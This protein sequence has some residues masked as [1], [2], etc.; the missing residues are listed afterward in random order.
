[1]NEQAMYDLY[2]QGEQFDAE[3]RRRMVELWDNRAVQVNFN[4]GERADGK[5]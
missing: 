3:H 1:M 4:T 2:L 5:P